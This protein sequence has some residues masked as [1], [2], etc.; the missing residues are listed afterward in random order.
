MDNE[1]QEKTRQKIRKDHPYVNKTQQTTHKTNNTDN[2]E[3]IY[4]IKTKQNN[5]NW[6]K[7]KHKIFV[8]RAV[9]NRKI[10]K[11]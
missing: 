10:E 7:N 1:Q 5:S 4:E 8:Q 6:L 3:H 11:K 9:A 2:T